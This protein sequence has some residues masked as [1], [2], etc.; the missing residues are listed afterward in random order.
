MANGYDKGYMDGLEDSAKNQVIIDEKRAKADEA[1]AD[2]LNRLNGIFNDFIGIS[3]DIF[4]ADEGKAKFNLSRVFDI[5]NLETNEKRFLIG[6]LDAISDGDNSESQKE[7]F[8]NIR[9]YLGITS[10]PDDVKLSD[11]ENIDSTEQKEAIWFCICEFL[12]LK[13]C[14]QLSQAKYSDIFRHYEF[15][16]ERLNEKFL[17]ISI[18]YEKHGENFF[19]SRFDISPIDYISEEYDHTAEQRED[20]DSDSSD[21]YYDVKS[22]IR[23]IIQ[24]RIDGIGKDLEDTF[25]AA[26]ELRNRVPVS[27]KL[28]KTKTEYQRI[29]SVLNKTKILAVPDSVVAIRK[30]KSGYIVFT[31]YALYLPDGKD[32]AKIPYKDIELKDLKAGSG[33]H[34]KDSELSITYYLDKRTLRTVKIDDSKVN[35]EK[36]QNLLTEIIQN[37]TP[38]ET[39]KAVPFEKLPEEARKIFVA[40]L[41]YI[42]RNSN[43]SLMEAFVLAC[44]L[45]VKHLWNDITYMIRNKNKYDENVEL[46]KSL[47]PYPSEKIISVVACELMFNALAISQ[48]IKK[49]NNK[50]IAS[51]NPYED[52]L[53]RKLYFAENSS[54]EDFYLLKNGA[55]INLQIILGYKSASE[56]QKLHEKRIESFS[57]SG[58]SESQYLI[59]SPLHSLVHS[60]SPL[61]QGAGWVLLPPLMVGLTVKKQVDN[62]SEKKQIIS[63]MLEKYTS[64]Q[65]LYISSHPRD[66]ATDSFTDVIF[67]I[68]QLQK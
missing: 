17:A 58:I 43:H 3:A 57:Y 55:S 16:E 7:Y 54:R 45:N 14:V 12:F 41:A 27:E 60:N 50:G 26:K 65:K 64:I 38:A 22:K 15:K 31:T 51:L 18:L 42:L 62:K 44:D 19:A 9:K 34:K 56:L 35:E 23:E 29:I 59:A 46:F 61:L 37:V 68:K 28:I 8:I 66:Y 53:I 2:R 1:K 63:N 6:V 24:S 36:L 10:D 25:D 4:D 52:E 49:E 47:I 30:I 5:K 13:E 39:D 48:W 67:N 20:D 40:L 33:K 11:I 21:E 32:Y